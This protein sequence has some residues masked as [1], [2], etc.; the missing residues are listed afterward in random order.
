MRNYRLLINIH[1]KKA[2]IDCIWVDLWKEKWTIK[3]CPSVSTVSG[4]IIKKG[5]AHSSFFFFLFLFGSLNV[6]KCNLLVNLL[7]NKFSLKFGIALKNVCMCSLWFFVECY[8]VTS[9]YSGKKEH[10]AVLEKSEFKYL[11]F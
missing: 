3:W 2:V 6:L 1:V 5:A 8:I 7:S 9:V 11:E 10:Y 4:D